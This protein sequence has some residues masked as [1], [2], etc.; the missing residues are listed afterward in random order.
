MLFFGL[1]HLFQNSLASNSSILHPSFPFQSIHP[2]WGSVSWGLVDGFPVVSVF[3]H[4]ALQSSHLCILSCCILLVPS[5]GLFSPLSHVFPLT[6]PYVPPSSGAISS[7]TLILSN[8]FCIFDVRAT[9]EPTLTSHPIS[10]QSYIQIINVI[11]H[12]F[13][14][15]KCSI[16][17]GIHPSFCG[18]AH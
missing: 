11:A 5:P 7:P 10:I 1:F 12:S 17:L 6:L 2:S 13:D 3:L 4:H 16:V 14:L 9:N 18:H 8:H 15:N